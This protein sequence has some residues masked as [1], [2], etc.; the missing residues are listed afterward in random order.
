M[1]ERGV[2]KDSTQ[3]V[4]KGEERVEERKILGHF[5]RRGDERSV[6]FEKWS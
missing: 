1:E 3:Y 6:G 2:E 5:E 4:R